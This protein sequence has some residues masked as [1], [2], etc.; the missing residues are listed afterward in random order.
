MPQS[1]SQAGS[2][3]AFERDMS[4]WILGV[5]ALFFLVVILAEIAASAGWLNPTPIHHLMDTCKAILLPVV[6]LVLGHY[7]GARGR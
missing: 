3:R 6:T 2:N 7:F 4:K 5:I 1:T